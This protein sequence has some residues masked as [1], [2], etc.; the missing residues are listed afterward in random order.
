MIARMLGYAAGATASGTAAG[1][2]G[3]TVITPGVGTVIGMVIGMAAG[4][5]VDHLMND[6]M[7]AN[8]T[9][10][11]RDTLNAMEYEIWSHATVGLN[12]RLTG[13]VTATKESHSSALTNIVQEKKS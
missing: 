1:A 6:R 12:K 9:R 2:A 5:A 7:K 4:V 13:L 8:I 10:E 11:T 3:G